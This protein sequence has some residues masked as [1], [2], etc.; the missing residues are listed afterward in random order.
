MSLLDDEANDVEE[1]VAEGGY[2]ELFLFNF[3]SRQ[4][5]GAHEPNL[6]MIQNEACDEWV[7]QGNNTRNE[8]CEWLFTKEHANCIIVA[9]NFQGYDSYFI[10][11]YLHKN[12]LVPVWCKDPHIVHTHVQDQIHRLAEFHS[13]E[14][15]KLSENLWY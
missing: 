13:D 11:Q 8:F 12:S 7:F 14:T 3:E 2:N 6:C 5:N 10:Q 4:E 9:H 15:G 1:D